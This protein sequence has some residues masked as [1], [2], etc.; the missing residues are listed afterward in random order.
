MMLYKSNC[1]SSRNGYYR[2]LM[3]HN[4]Q[5]PVPVQKSEFLGSIF[6]GNRNMLK[7]RK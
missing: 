5:V 3:I 1:I 6:I 4:K 7:R 2:K